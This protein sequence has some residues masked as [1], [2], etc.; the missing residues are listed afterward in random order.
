MMPALNSILWCV[1]QTS[2]VTTVALV[3]AGSLR[4]RFPQ[5]TS[6]LLAGAG[7]CIL[8]LAVLALI[9]QSHW[10]LLDA[11]GSQEILT[12]S[13]GHD[14]HSSSFSDNGSNGK[15]EISSQSKDDSMD[16]VLATSEYT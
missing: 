3:I 6:A 9:P 14:Q 11:V 15:A 8:V 4:G 1:V 10:S 13:K 12:D 5:W 16:A 7:L 2:I